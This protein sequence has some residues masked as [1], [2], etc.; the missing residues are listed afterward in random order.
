VQFVDYEQSD[1]FEY[2]PLLPPSTEDVPELRLADYYVVALYQFV[3][4]IGLSR[5]YAHTLVENLGKQLPPLF[6]FL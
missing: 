1:L 3:I 5:E 2:L 6:E 4:R